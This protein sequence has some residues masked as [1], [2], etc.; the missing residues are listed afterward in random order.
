MEIDKTTL[1]D[2]SIFSNEEPYSIFHKLDFTTTSGGSHKLRH[3]FSHSLSS[4]EEIRN[5]QDT[6]KFI[7]ANQQQ[8][9]KI[10]TNGTLMVVHKFY[11]HVIDQL[12]NTPSTASA[13]AYKILHSQDYSLV[14]YSAIHCFDLVK[15]MNQFV[16][17]LL[18]DDTPVLLKRLLENVRKI[19]GKEQFTVV[20]KKG[21]ASELT[22]A[23][24]LGL[25]GFIRYHYKQHILELMNSYHQL[26]AWYSMALATK[27]YNLSFPNFI[28]QKE[29][30]LEANSLY[31]ILLKEPVAYD[32]SLNKDVNFIFLTGAN[33]AGKST[34]IKAIGT[35]VFLAHIGMGVPAGSLK[36]T[37]FDGLLSNINVIDNIV[38]GES[39]FYNEVQRIKDTI[40]KINNGKKWLVLIDELFKGTNIQ[41]AMKCSAA[42]IKGLIKIH[43]SLFILSTH[44][45][46]IAEELE[47]YPNIDFRYFETTVTEDHLEFTYQLRPG[48]SDDRLGYLILKREGVVDL[49]SKL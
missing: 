45:Y 39:Y 30:A 25:A 3:I 15:G 49:L 1:H 6:I 27:E 47:Q 21:S 33:M 36:L 8:W 48:T 24:M 5:V 37:L 22:K 31:H 44:L 17:D 35:A 32:V 34:F 14:K 12:P 42:V 41:D 28:E 40:T 20:L 26:D 9:P 18:R 19:V 4:I 46:E 7:H 2:L 11:E 43:N 13:Y 23:E 10:I 16:E 38:K 29:P